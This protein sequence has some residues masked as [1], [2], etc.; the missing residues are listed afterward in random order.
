MVKKLKVFFMKK[1]CKRLIRKSLGLKK[2]LKIKEINYM[3]NGNVIIIV[4]TV[5]LIKK[6]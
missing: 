1:N 4:L 3:S 5:G 6:T 2:L